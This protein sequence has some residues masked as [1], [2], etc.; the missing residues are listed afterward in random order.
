MTDNQYLVR[1]YSWDNVIK[2]PS[3]VG[4]N[5]IPH[6]AAAVLVWQRKRP[7]NPITIDFSKV[8]KAYSNGM[9]PLI[10]M[11]A[12]LK[13]EAYKVNV[14]L[15][16][17]DKVRK[18]FRSNN[19]AYYLDDKYPKSE[20]QHDRHLVTRQF[21]SFSEIPAIITDFMDVMLRNVAMPKDIVSA[22]EWSVNEICDNVI[23][24]SESPVGGFVQLISYPKKNLISFTVADAGKGILN[25]LREAIPTLRT[26]VQAIGEAIKEG[27]TRNK[28]VG[29]GNG[30]AGTMRITTMSGGHIDITS[31]S[32]RFYANAEDNETHESEK[33]QNY[34][35]TS[36]SGQISMNKTFSLGQALVFNG[37][38]Y[39]TLN[40]IDLEY[41]M[42]DKDCLLVQMKDETTGVGTRSAGKQMKTKILNF[43]ESKPGFPIFIGWE[44]IPVISSSFADEFMGKLFLELGPM[45]FS[46]TIRNRNMETIVQ[47]LLDKAIL[48]R[49][50]Q[51][52][53]H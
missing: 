36:V 31:G 23:N 14:I 22:L 27:V 40:I 47:Q 48:Q 38:S 52:A 1:Y 4:A 17:E 41:E 2:L 9:L 19:W 15:P 46:A 42:Q 29:Q 34:K 35:G 53:V 49:V 13:L 6:F 30:L 3:K 12:K 25:T 50:S 28:E 18:M 20:W 51:E 5:I 37:I 21:T 10:A 8:L 32:G 39:E 11:I 45:R 7:H 43:I 24:H 44:G 16:K 33:M 26:D